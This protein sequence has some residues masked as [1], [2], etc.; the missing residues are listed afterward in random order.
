ML[1]AEPAEVR[2]NV[3]EGVAVEMGELALTGMRAVVE[4]KAQSASPLGSGEDL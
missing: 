1:E 4:A 2:G 3:I